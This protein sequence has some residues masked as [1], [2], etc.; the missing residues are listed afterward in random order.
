LEAEE[1]GCELRFSNTF[2]VGER[3]ANSI[4]CGWHNCLELLEESI[5]GRPANWETITRDR[6]VE[7][8]W[9]YRN[10]PRPE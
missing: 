4:V 3:A 8:Y 1:G 7:L 9:H 2:D 6:V 10:K 5:E